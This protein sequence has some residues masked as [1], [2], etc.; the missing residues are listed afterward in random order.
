MASMRQHDSVAVPLP[1]PI[2]TKEKTVV[3][4]VP[5][6]GVD[7]T[8]QADTTIVGTSAID[9][10]FSFIEPRSDTKQFK[11]MEDYFL[12]ILLIF[13]L[14][15]RFLFYKIRTEVTKMRNEFVRLSVL[16]QSFMVNVNF[17][18]E[19]DSI[20]TESKFRDTDTQVLVPAKEIDELRILQKTNEGYFDRF[21]KKKK[22]TDEDDPVVS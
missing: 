5:A 3:E 12:Y 9:T 13:L 7:S 20:K 14:A 15:E 19:G 4:S 17:K 8:E 18:K 10:A 11:I 2:R 21:F 1:K 22:E 6:I 16:L